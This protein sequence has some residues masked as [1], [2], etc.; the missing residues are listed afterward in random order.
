MSGKYGDTEAAASMSRKGLKKSR[1][2]ADAKYQ[3]HGLVPHAEAPEG[4][5]E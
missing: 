5:V 3:Y 1:G 4:L 2:M